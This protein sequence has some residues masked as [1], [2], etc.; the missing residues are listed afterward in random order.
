MLAPRPQPAWFRHGW[1]RLALALALTLTLTPPPPPHP[2]HGLSTTVGALGGGMVSE[3]SHGGIVRLGERDAPPCSRRSATSVAVVLNDCAAA[4]WSAVARD[5]PSRRLGED[6]SEKVGEGEGG[7]GGMTVSRHARCVAS[8]RPS[9]AAR[10]SKS[11]SVA[12]ADS[13]P[14][15]G[16]A[17]CRLGDAVGENVGEGDRG[18]SGRLRSPSHESRLRSKPFRSPCSIVA[19]GSQGEC[20]VDAN[21]YGLGV[22]LGAP[23]AKA[24]GVGSFRE[25]LPKVARS[26]TDESLVFPLW[27]AIVVHACKGRLARLAGT[28][29]VWGRRIWIKNLLKF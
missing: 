2:N 10:D 28:C 7:V 6:G 20:S 25:R 16:S 9:A 19:G 15:G 17:H 4:N 21:E 18:V 29:G 26:L 8:V 22:S 1:A 24:L 27:V 13:A 23:K 12:S 14:G 11:S 5:S 3:V